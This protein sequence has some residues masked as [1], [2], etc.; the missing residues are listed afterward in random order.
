[1]RTINDDPW[2]SAQPAAVAPE[3]P[4]PATGPV[5]AQIS[6]VIHHSPD[7]GYAVLSVALEGTAD[8]GETTV[9]VG[10]MLKPYVGDTVK[11]HGAW[12]TH[13]KFGSQ[14]KFV[15]YEAPLP[16]NA[17]QAEAYLAS[18][19]IP[20]I[21]PSTARAIVAHFGDETLRVLDED[22]ERLVE[23]PNI[24]KKKLRIITEGWAETIQQRAIEIALTTV[25][26]SAAHAWAIWDEFGA[27]G[28][29]MVTENPY[30]LTKAKGVGFLTCDQIAARLGWDARDP[31]RLSAGIAHALAE[32]EKD[33]H[34]YLPEPRL[35]KAASELLGVAPAT[36][37]SALELAVT[38]GR[39][40]LDGEACYTSR[41]HYIE[42]DLASQ[43]AR[44]AQ[45]PLMAPSES[46]REQIEKLLAE[47]GLTRDQER[48]V[49]AVLHSPLTVLTGGPGVGKS[50]TIGTV[51]EAAKIC[52]WQTL[53]CAPTGRAARRM[54]EMADGAESATVH[55]LI[56]YGQGQDGAP[57]RDGDD[58]LNA[59]LLICDESSMLDVS[60]ARH[61]TR[62]IRAGTR[63]LFVGDV[64]QLP[65]VGPGSVLRDLIASGKAPTIALTQIFRQGKDS[66]IVQV[67][68]TVN[69]GK[70]PTLDGWEDLHLWPT[71]EAD[72]AAAYVE[73]MVCEHLPRAFGIDAADIQV[74]APQRKGSCG[75]NALNRRLQSRIN[76]AAGP[77]Y[78]AVI[79]GETVYFRPGDRAMIIKNNY[80]KGARGVFNGT[81]VKV[82]DVDPE[83][84]KHAVTVLTD[85][86]ETVVYES[87]EVAQ[88]ALAY[89]VTIHKSQ[90]SQYP[91]VVMPFT[92]QSYKMLVRNLLYTG[93]TRAQ[94]RVVLVG[95][96]KA[97]R[98][99]VETVDALKRHT[100][101][102]R[103]LAAA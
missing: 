92:M 65:S 30:A 40:V 97:I 9:A 34:C 31:R 61:L 80:D 19:R 35:L 85:E 39:L 68:H 14:F 28:A 91:C 93:I 47:R 76:P 22:I 37:Q 7:T 100:G 102:D 11:L 90:G 99:A 4:R 16:A 1:M 54:S 29:A 48:A 81:P 55:R 42:C 50:H 44:L 82:V 2:V 53:L 17:A 69:A 78:E 94:T 21:G 10:T 72:K 25:G 24:G 73:A 77:E 67:A 66:G 13:P 60:L 84:K 56:G 5:T 75:I 52:R 20:G 62:A 57:A 58:P 63:V 12:T 86:G 74:L 103:R 41:M 46:Q 43:F 71:D 87:S 64:D 98:K 88:L 101:L 83:D 6:H 59:D 15:S 49:L 23:V 18:G 38:E 36:C 45:E 70:H 79:G 8:T 26:A 27:D 96:P 3:M 95:D 51:V 89:A 33:G 32:A